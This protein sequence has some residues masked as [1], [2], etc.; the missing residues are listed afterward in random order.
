MASEPYVPTVD[1]ARVDEAHTALVGLRGS[2]GQLTMAKFSGYPVL[3]QL[4]GEGDLVEAFMAFQR[5]LRRYE[6]GTR[7]EA[8]AALSISSDAETVLDRLT[9]TAEHFDYQDQRTIRHWSDRGLRSI[10]EDLVAMA[11]VRGRLGRE[12]LT[13]TL[14]GTLDHGYCLV[15]DQMDFASLDSAPPSV[16]VWLWRDEEQADEACMELTS[17]HARQAEDGS[18]RNTR[19]RVA[20]PD[21][22]SLVADQERRLTDKVVTVAVQGRSAPART[23]TWRNEASLLE[24]LVVEV[25]TH[26]TMVTATLEVHGTRID[27]EAPCQGGVSVQSSSRT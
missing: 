1:P 11:T 15:V 27:G 20:L 21:L 24:D 23:V 26:R 19:W 22:R 18:Y 16:T 4:C 10:A 2:H 8:A 13:L 14:T 25:V 7:F 3:V 9:M 17:S 12:L 5:E 6:R